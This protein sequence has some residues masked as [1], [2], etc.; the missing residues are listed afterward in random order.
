[1]VKVLDGPGGGGYVGPES[2]TAAAVVAEWVPLMEAEE[3]PGVVVSELL[4]LSRL[5][6][7]LGR[8]VRGPVLKMHSRLDS[9][10]LNG[11]ARPDQPEKST[12]RKR[13]RGP[14]KRE[15][16]EHRIVSVL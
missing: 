10:H 11:C 15:K 12:G 16:L 1:M 4:W 13:G 14:F 3:A 2:A 9:E 6:N 7:C 5:F 8:R